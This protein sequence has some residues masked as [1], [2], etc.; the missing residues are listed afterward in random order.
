M[1]SACSLTGGHIRWPW[2]NQEVSPHQTRDLWLR[3]LELFSLNNKKK[4]SVLFK[5]VVPAYGILL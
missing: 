5:H 1:S 3:D 2:A 4:K